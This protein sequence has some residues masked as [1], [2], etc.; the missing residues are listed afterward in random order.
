M[1]YKPR[2]T[3]ALQVV[4]GG[5][6][7]KMPVEVEAGVG[8]AAKTVGELRQAAT[9][10]GNLAIATPQQ[11]HADST[12]KVSKANAAARVTPKA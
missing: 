3:A 6:P 5:L 11:F 12:V 8:I 1:R 2:S 9:W 10:P 7:D 4:L